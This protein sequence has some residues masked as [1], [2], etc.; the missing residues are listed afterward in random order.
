MHRDFSAR[1]RRRGAEHWLI[2]AVLMFRRFLCRRARQ[3]R[4]LSH[5]ATGAANHQKSAPKLSAI[6]GRNGTQDATVR[7]AAT[8]VVARSATGI[9]GRLGTI[10]AAAV[11]RRSHGMSRDDAGHRR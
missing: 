10:G 7:G 6:Q 3:S 9:G 1:D 11:R 4:D 5:A 8:M 2:E